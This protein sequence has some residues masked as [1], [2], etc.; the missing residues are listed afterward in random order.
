MEINWQVSE[1]VKHSAKHLFPSAPRWM[2]CTSYSWPKKK[3]VLKHSTFQGHTGCSIFT[4][5]FS[6]SWLMRGSKS[7]TR[8]SSWSH[9]YKLLLHINITP[10]LTAG[11]R[12]R[13][14]K[15]SSRTSHKLMTTQSEIQVIR[16][17]QIYSHNHWDEFINHETGAALVHHGPQSIS[18]TINYSVWGWP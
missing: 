17:I 16:W 1:A 5:W 9:W 14:S 8:H 6:R 15:L 10:I 2:F 11:Q 12:R 13:F 3:R 7:I 4:V 18:I